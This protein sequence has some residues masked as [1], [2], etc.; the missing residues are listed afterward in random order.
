MKNPLQSKAVVICLVVIAGLVIAAN[1]LKFPPTRAAA[2]EQGGFPVGLPPDLSPDKFEVP[3]RPSIHE[4]LVSW[5]ASPDRERLRR[6]PF[7]WGDRTVVPATN[8]VLSVSSLKLQAISIDADKSLAVLNQRVIGPGDKVGEYVV[9]R[10][11]PTE[12]WL[13]GPG[14]RLTLRLAR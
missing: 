5:S 3:P 11:L 7:A 6:D 8:T 1:V 4:Q 13:R 14:G 2:R 12:V 9:E 10:I